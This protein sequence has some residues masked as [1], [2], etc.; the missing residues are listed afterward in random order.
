MSRACWGFHHPHTIMSQDYAKYRGGRMDEHF[1]HMSEQQFIS[2]H[3]AQLQC[4]PNTKHNISRYLIR[5]GDD[6]DQ[7]NGYNI[8][9]P[10]GEYG[11]RTV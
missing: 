3:Q 4:H 2:I 7:S 11:P 6:L 1:L 5:R 9:Q 8:G 10:L